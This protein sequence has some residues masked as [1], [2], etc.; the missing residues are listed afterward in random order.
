MLVTRAHITWMKL[1][2]SCKILAGVINVVVVSTLPRYALLFTVCDLKAALM[3]VQC[4]LIR[5]LMLISLNWAIHCRN[6]QQKKNCSTKVVGA[7]NYRTVTRW[8]KKFRSGCQNFDDPANSGFWGNESNLG[9]C[10][11]RVRSELGMLPNNIFLQLYKT[12]RKSR[13]TC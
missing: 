9:D 2:K 12:V 6:Q 10:Q 11:L 5:Q 7:F 3:N 13:S 8:L 4:I 1:F